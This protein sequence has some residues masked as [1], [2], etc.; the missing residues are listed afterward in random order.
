[1]YFLSFVIKK[2]N[3]KLSVISKEAVV[4]EQ[5]KASARERQLYKSSNTAEN[6]RDK[7]SDLIK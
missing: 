6:P 5:H 4:R 2:L 1:M 3:Q 7:D